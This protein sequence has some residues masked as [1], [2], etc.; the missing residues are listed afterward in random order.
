MTKTPVERETDPLTP[1]MP[2]TNVPSAA[3]EPAVSVSVAEPVPAGMKVESNVAVTSPGRPNATRF[4]PATDVAFTVR[5]VGVFNSNRC[6]PGD[7]LSASVEVEADA[8]AVIAR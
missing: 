8:Q 7:T 4:T 1:A 5:L 2:T 3:A 6:D